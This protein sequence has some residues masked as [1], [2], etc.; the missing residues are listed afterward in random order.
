MIPA[1]DEAVSSRIG[2]DVQ[3]LARIPLHQPRAT[4]RWSL[5]AAALEQLWAVRT[6]GLVGGAQRNSDA[7]R[8]LR[9]AGLTTRFGAPTD[10]GIAITRCI[11]RPSATFV[12][13]AAHGGRLSTWSYSATAETGLVR[14][15]V[16]VP[17]LFDGDEDERTRLDLVPLGVAIGHLLAWIGMTPAWAVGADVPLVLGDAVIEARIDRAGVPSEALPIDDWAFQRLWD[18]PRWVSLRGW[19]EATARGFSVIAAGDA[20]VFRRRPGEVPGSSTLEPVPVGTV[21]QDVVVMF[22]GEGPGAS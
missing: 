13:E 7:G 8:E 19:S 21:L 17:E 15:G 22:T 6:R 20:G 18:Q 3:S 1:R 2:H 5:S 9:D 10:A 16:S 11:E 14:S 12:V 4:S